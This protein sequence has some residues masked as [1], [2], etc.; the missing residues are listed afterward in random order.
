MYQNAK[1]FLLIL[2]IVFDHIR[3]NSRVKLTMT[4]GLPDPRKVHLNKKE[5]DN[6]FN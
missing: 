4:G 5:L 2:K 1:I 6:I 3:S